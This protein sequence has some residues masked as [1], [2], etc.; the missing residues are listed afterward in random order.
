ME[1]KATA[2]KVA[3]FDTG[4]PRA[5]GNRRASSCTRATSR[6]PNSRLPCSW[7][8]ERVPCRRSP[9]LIG[10]TAITP[11]IYKAERILEIAKEMAKI[12]GSSQTCV[13]G[14][15]VADTWRTVGAR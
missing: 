11:S 8:I 15:S 6:R 4:L 1:Q 5:F 12:C 3:F 13:I 9:D 10:A 7:A 2:V 14:G